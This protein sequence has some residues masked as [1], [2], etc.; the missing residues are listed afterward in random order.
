[1]EKK[2]L[3]LLWKVTFYTTVFERKK[4]KQ[5]NLNEMKMLEGVLVK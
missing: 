2:L 5:I 4:G 3:F 1:M